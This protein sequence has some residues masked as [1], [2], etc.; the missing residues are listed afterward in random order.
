MQEKSW[1]EQVVEKLPGK[2]VV[3]RSPQDSIPVQSILFGTLAA[4]AIL[5]VG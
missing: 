4:S 5:Q 2:I 3:Q 1:Q